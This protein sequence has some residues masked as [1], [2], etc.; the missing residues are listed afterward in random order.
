MGGGVC[1][2]GPECTHHRYSNLMVDGTKVR[3]SVTLTG[4]LTDRL[5][6][7]RCGGSLVE[8][9]RH[10]FEHAP[11]PCRTVQQAAAW[12]MGVGG[13]CIYIAY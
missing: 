8:P 13:T 7:S 1:L 12:G 5:N 6:Y 11:L 2:S 9:D 10:T 4:W 3:R